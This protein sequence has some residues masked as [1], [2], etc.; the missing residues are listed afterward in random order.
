MVVCDTYY[1]NYDKWPL[2]GNQRICS[3]RDWNQVVQ[4]VENKF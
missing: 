3:G 2:P 1:K 4:C